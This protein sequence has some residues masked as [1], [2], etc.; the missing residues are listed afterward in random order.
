MTGEATMLTVDGVPTLRFER[1]LKHPPGKVW[2]AV[3]DP[4]EMGHWFPAS[5]ETE[6]RPGAPIRFT[7]PG[8]PVVGG[9]QR[10]EVLE[11]DPPR[12]FMFRWNNDVIR[13]ELIPDGTGTR[14]IFTQTVSGGRIGRLGA[15]RTAAGWD[16]CL[17]ALLAHL[18]GADAP[19]RTDWATPIEHYVE[20]FDLDE[21]ETT[22]TT[23]RFARDLVWKPV[24][25]LWHLLVEGTDPKTGEPPPSPAVCPE[26]PPGKI[27]AV[28][29]PHV[30]EYEWLHDGSPAGTVRWEFSAD[31]NLGVRV[32]L[33][34][35]GPPHL[36]AQ[37]VSAWKAHLR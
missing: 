35:T 5:V 4:A 18:D 23:V 24:D 20:K 21:A 16:T 30:L 26:V 25:A 33:T 7:F 17:D 11:V 36:H 15:G 13:I 28:E 9:E 19:S 14:L 10:G 37:A 12:V 27:T 2:R 8:E 6:L 1:V 34:Q 32:E 31:P 29:A 3:S 22:E